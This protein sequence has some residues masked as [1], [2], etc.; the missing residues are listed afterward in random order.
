MIACQEINFHWDGLQRDR[1]SSLGIIHDGLQRNRV[2]RWASA[3]MDR[4][5]IDFI[6][7]SWPWWIAKRSSFI[8]WC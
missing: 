6:T 8:S 3:M 7:W 2:H 4:K 5:E 1:V